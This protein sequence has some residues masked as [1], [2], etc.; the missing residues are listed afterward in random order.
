ML[1]RKTVVFLDL[2]RRQEPKEWILARE[3]HFPFLARSGRP[4]FQFNDNTRSHDN[5]DIDTN[6]LDTIQV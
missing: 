3:P 6:T 1:D 4:D 5:D 2:A